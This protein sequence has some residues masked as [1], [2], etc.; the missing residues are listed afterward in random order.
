MVYLIGFRIG[1]LTAQRWGRQIRIT[2]GTTIPSS[3]TLI[4]ELFDSY[5]V[6][7][8]CP[9][10]NNPYGYG[11]KIYCNLHKSFSF[12]LKKKIPRWI[13]EDEE[14][15][16]A[17]L[18]GFFDAEGSISISISRQKVGNFIQ[19]ALHIS[20]YDKALNEALLNKLRELGYNARF[21]RSRGRI[22]GIQLCRKKEI[23]ELTSKLPIRHLE[24]LRQYK[25]FL[26]T[27]DAKRWDEVKDRVITLRNET[28]NEKKEY[29]KKARKEWL[30]RHKNSCLVDAQML[31]K[32]I[33]T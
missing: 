3:S 12:L 5:T 13:L 17:F 7:K 23:M 29:I 6:V 24:K 20:N 8:E 9:Q 1:D 33:R 15:F 32:R 25:L 27:I 31:N 21:R 22:I 4:H 30:R 19:R 16:Y 2:M 11:W 18:A 26:D 10:K 14:H 28:E